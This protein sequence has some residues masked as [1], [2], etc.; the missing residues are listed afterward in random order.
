[1]QGPLSGDSVVVQADAQVGGNIQLVNL[2]VV[3]ALTTP[4][5]ASVQVSGQAQVGILDYDYHYGDGTADIIDRLGLHWIAH[6]SAGQ[7][8]LAEHQAGAFL[9]AI[10]DHVARMADCDV[11]LYQAGADPHI[12]D[13]LGGF[14]TTAELAE[15]D[16]R[17]FQ[18]LHDRGIPVAWNLAGGYQQPLSK[19]V[20]IHKNT[21]RACQAIY[22]AS[23]SRASS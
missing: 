20:A 7:T 18:G 11:V 9:N 19:V 5:G 17:V 22:G 12:E 6:Y 14:L 2:T 3:G 23:A 8:F 10:P 21:Y 13:P 1:M 16:R 4:V 15:R